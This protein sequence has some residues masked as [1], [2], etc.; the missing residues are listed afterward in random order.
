MAIEMAG[1]L[2]GLIAGSFGGLMGVG[3]GVIMVPLMTELLKFR[4]QEAHG[5]SL[6]AVVF[7]GVV[8]TVVYHLHG[9]VDIPTAV[10][11]AGLAL[12]AVHWGARF[13][14]WLPEWKLKRYFGVLLLFVTV[15]LLLKPFLPQ[16]LEGTLPLW[17]HWAILVLLGAITG[18]ISGMMGVGGGIF[19]VPMLVLFAGIDQYTAQG[20]SLL[21][22]IPGSMV[23]AWTYWKRGHIRPGRL[24]GLVT[25]IIAGVYGGGSL[26]HLLPARELR[27]AFALLLVGTAFRYL[28]VKPGPAAECKPPE[29]RG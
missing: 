26:A 10:V 23:G 15:L 13:S 3:G 18:F 4:Q 7:T 29:G 16:G 2:V 28:H 19:L 11:L 8:G 5:T 27:L 1:L 24:P 9:S 21:V 17:I 22:M 14:C 6:I 25:G 20:T 12:L